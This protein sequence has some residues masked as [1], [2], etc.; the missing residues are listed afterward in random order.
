MHLDFSNC[1]LTNDT[2]LALEEISQFRLNPRRNRINPTQYT[3]Y[4]GGNDFSEDAKTSFEA[5][6]TQAFPGVKILYETSPDT[7]AHTP[8]K[9]TPREIPLPQKRS[10]KMSLSKSCPDMHHVNNGVFHMELAPDVQENGTYCYDTE[11]GYTP[12]SQKETVAP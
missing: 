8:Q 1:E 6:F 9:S 5:A 4:L 2:L 7:I 12:F 10:R 11:N 3:L